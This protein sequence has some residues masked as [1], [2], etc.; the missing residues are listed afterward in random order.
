VGILLYISTLENKTHILLNP[1]KNGIVVFLK[2]K[3][4]SEYSIVKIKC[5]KNKYAI[6]IS[7]L[8][9]K[10]IKTEFIHLTL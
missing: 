3:N 10:L 4:L 1:L 2:G 9:G 8:Q 6:N 5:Y 7:N